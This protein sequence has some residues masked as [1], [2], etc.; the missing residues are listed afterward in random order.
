MGTEYVVGGRLGRAGAGAEGTTAA[1]VV[2]RLVVVVVVGVVM[3]RLVVVV[4][5]EVVGVVVVV[6]RVVLGLVDASGAVSTLGVET[7][8]GG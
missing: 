7:R 1:T 5:V 3:G 6:E 4:V 8:T 2:A